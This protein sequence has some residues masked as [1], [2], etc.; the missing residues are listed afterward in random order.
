MTNISVVFELS[1]EI[2]KGLADGTLE[3]VGGVIRTV[4][5][6]KIVVWLTEAGEAASQ[7]SGIPSI[8]TSPQMLMGMQVANLAVSVAGF[9]L[10]YNKLQQ[11]ERQLQGIDQK[12]VAL[13]EAQ[14]WLDKKHLIGHL[15]PICGALGTLSGIHLIQDKSVAEAKLISAD[16]KLDDANIFFRSILG[17]MLAKKMEQERPE[18]F[19]ACYRAWLMASQGR[20]QTM[21]VLGEIQAAHDRA[22]KFKIEHQSFGR[23]FIAVR[24]DPLR[25]LSSERAS[26][27]AEPLLVELGQQCAGAHEILKGRALQLEYMASNGLCLEDLPDVSAARNKNYALLY[28]DN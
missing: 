2:A 9:A 4:G 17:E 5:D 22:E 23:E 25:K 7:G 6:K 3:R 21:A 13:T 19:A 12:L 24:R 28:F 1:A 8:L 15:A 14:D 26:S 20:I 16:N 18:E 10:I 11:V 27:N